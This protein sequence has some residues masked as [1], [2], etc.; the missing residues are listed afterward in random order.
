METPNMTGWQEGEAL[1]GTDGGRLSQDVFSFGG[2]LPRGEF[3]L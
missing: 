1:S 2:R 3:Q